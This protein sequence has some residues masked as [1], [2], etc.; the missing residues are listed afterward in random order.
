ML[1]IVL[2]ILLIIVVVIATAIFLLIRL[3]FV[4][5]AAKGSY[6]TPVPL[7]KDPAQVDPGACNEQDGRESTSK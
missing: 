6:Y 5:G 7:P 2:T 4:V 1:R 3:A